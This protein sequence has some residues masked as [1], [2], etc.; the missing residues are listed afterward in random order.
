MAGDQLESEVDIGG[1][2]TMPIDS[3]QVEDQAQEEVH[4]EK[5]EGDE[6]QVYEIKSIRGKGRSEIQ[7]RGVERKSTRIICPI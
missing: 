6:D 4:H 2:D 1:R 7:A 3:D 5:A